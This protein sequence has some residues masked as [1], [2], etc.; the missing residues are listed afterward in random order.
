MKK[1]EELQEKYKSLL[2]LN[3]P[4][5]CGDGWYALLNRVLFKIQRYIE[6]KNRHNNGN[7]PPLEFSI[8]TIKEK[9][10]GLRIYFDGGD[11]YIGGIISLAEDMSYDICENCGTNQNV[12]RTN[13]WI[14]SICEPCSKNPQVNPKGH[15]WYSKE[16][17]DEIRK[18]QSF[19]TTPFSSP[20]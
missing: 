8:S 9:F 12:G 11:E 7:V 20:E 4:I 3:Y 18:S 6:F 13:G 16:K 1:V 5:S 15:E 17:L 19:G 2:Q 10:G 14:R